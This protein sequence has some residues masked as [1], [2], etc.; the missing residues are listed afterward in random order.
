MAAAEGDEVERRFIFAL[1]MPGVDVQ[2]APYPRPD[3][4]EPSPLKERPSAQEAAP[5]EP[6]HTAA[7]P[8]TGGAQG[9]KPPLRRRWSTLFRQGA[10]RGAAPGPAERRFSIGMLGVRATHAPASEA[11]A[12]S[13]TNPLRADSAT[14]RR[15]VA[16]QGALALG[17]GLARPRTDE[18]QAAPPRHSDRRQSAYTVTRSASERWRSAAAMVPEEQADAGRSSRRISDTLRRRGGGGASEGAAEGEPVAAR[19][20]APTARADALSDAKS[21]GEAAAD[22]LVEDTAP[23]DAEA[24][25]AAAASDTAAAPAEAAED[26]STAATKR[27]AATE[28]TAATG[29]EAAPA[30]EPAPQQSEQDEAAAEPAEPSEPRVWRRLLE[31]ASG[32]EYYVDVE[33]R[34]SQWQ[35]PAQGWVAVSDPKS[36]RSYFCCLETRKTVW[37]DPRV[38]HRAALRQKLRR[39]AGRATAG[40]GASQWRR[41]TDPKTGREYFVNLTTRETRWTP[42][43]ADPQ[44]APPAADPSPAA[45]KSEA[46]SA[47]PASVR[48]SVAA[49]AAKAAAARASAETATETAAEERPVL[50]ERAESMGPRDSSAAALRWQRAARRRSVALRAQNLAMSSPI[51]SVVGASVWTPGADTNGAAKP[52]ASAGGDDGSSTSSDWEDE[53]EAE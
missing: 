45:V 29:T 36:G 6:V 10:S 15:A 19:A 50:R 31:P 5:E 42:P 39:A 34:Q 23:V 17:Q 35:R 46:A 44:A 2:P 40:A 7:A 48:Y 22:G 21:V 37:E 25:A 52:A 9:S 1:P 51:Y 4:D 53:G 33:T 3:R 41:A 38:T 13:H 16:S 32:R 11:A 14:E 20:D 12:V 47:A 30:P 26:E 24:A 49:A 27:G 8:T 18:Q 43:G 28:T